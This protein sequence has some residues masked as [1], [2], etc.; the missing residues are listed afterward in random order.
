MKRALEMLG[1]GATGSVETMR[2]MGMLE[3]L[4]ELAPLAGLGLRELGPCQSI[5]RDPM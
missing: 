2:V 1:V 4:E 3:S 5:G